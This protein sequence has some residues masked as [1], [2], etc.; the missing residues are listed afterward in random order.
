MNPHESHRDTALGVEAGQL[1]PAH[2]LGEDLDPPPR[3]LRRVIG[4]GIVLAIAAMVFVV[5][6]VPSANQAWRVISQQT[7]SALVPVL[8]TPE[9]QTTRIVGELAGSDAEETLSEAS[10]LGR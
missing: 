6:S 7:D 2:T 4:T 5:Y 1:A 9:A 8:G 3:G 10:Q